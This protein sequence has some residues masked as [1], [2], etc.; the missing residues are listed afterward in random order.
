MTSCMLAADDG[1]VPQHAAGG[2]ARSAV[3]T[4]ATYQKAESDRRE[5]CT[6]APWS[7]CG[8][9]A[10][11]VGD[12]GIEGVADGSVSAIGRL[13]GNDSLGEAF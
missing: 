11:A 2:L 13:R 6:D 7:R 12:L 5:L 1:E 9:Y 3:L 4:F 8:L 10:T